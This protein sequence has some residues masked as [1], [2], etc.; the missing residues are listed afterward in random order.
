MYILEKEDGKCYM[1]NILP[2]GK[3]A[4]K[5]SKYFDFKEAIIVCN[6]AF[7]EV[8]KG[9]EKSLQDTGDGE[10]SIYFDEIVN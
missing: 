4:I 8:L 6:S 2:E 7:E 3:K 5:V 10:T 9:A 1:S